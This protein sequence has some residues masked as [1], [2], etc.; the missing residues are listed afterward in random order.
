[1]PE[2]VRRRR[3]GKRAFDIALSAVALIVL[4][5]VFGV[6]ALLVRLKLGSP[7]LF[8]QPRLGLGGRE[9]MIMKF[10]TMADDRGPNGEPKPDEQRLSRFGRLMRETS[11][12]ELPELINVIR[13]EMS[14]VGP[15]PL[16]SYYRDR[17]SPD[18]F[19]RHETPP[20]ITGWAQVRGR[21]AISWQKKFELDLW[22]V[23]HQ[24]YW[25]DLKILGLTFWNLLNR[26]GISQPGHATAEEFKGNAP[27]ESDYRA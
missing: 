21:N 10:R 7:V 26:E 3:L 23:D 15:R 2:A 12:D 22:Y 25:L 27:Q 1:M 16:H 20:G 18:Q 13:G 19:R 4:L 14:L 24:S 8:R 11:L 5:P 6:L 9:F 17:Y